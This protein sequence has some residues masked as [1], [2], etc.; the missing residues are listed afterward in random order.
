MSTHKKDL[1]T[2]EQKYEA[3]LK[4][5]RTELDLVDELAF[6][7]PLREQIASAIAIKLR[8]LLNDSK[9]NA[10][11]CT[12]INIKDKLLFQSDVLDNNDL[13]SNLVFSAKLC[14][15]QI[16]PTGQIFCVPSIPEFN[17]KLVSSFR[18]W[19]NEV[20]I[21]TKGDDGYLITRYDVVR[22]IANKEGGAHE[23]P[24]YE[25]EY[26]KAVYDNGFKIIDEKGEERTIANNF[27][28]ETLFV[29]A[30]EFLDAAD[31]Y[32]QV[33][34]KNLIKEEKTDNTII[35]ITY[36]DSNNHEIKRYY[37][38]SNENLNWSMILAYDYYR[39]AKYELLFLKGNR[40]VDKR[41]IMIGKLLII[42]DSQK[43]QIVYLR[44]EGIEN[45]VVLLKG[46][47]GYVQINQDADIINN[48]EEHNL[49]HYIDSFK[50]DKEQLNDFISK[51][52]IQ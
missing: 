14:A 7:D 3:S 15:L 20:V 36:Y 42:D 19:W 39:K 24:E 2:L 40:I 52:I 18:I 16:Q 27:Y 31:L 17:H 49:D 32:K 23:Q 50:G 51:Q 44:D 9:Q 34:S 43:R 47:K 33:I 22:T 45:Q 4:Y 25:D 48:H 11:L 1:P 38:N 8:V 21:D 26:Y 5:I 41:Q 6:N 12:Q 46:Q 13:P 37:P 35:Q 28:C 10:S 29:I 30:E